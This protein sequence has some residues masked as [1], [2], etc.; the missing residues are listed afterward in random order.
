[1]QPRLALTFTFTNSG[2]QPVEFDLVEVNSLLGNFAPRP[3]KLSLAPGAEG[4]M[5]P[6][7]SNLPPGLEGLEVTLT[8][9]HGNRSETQVL[10]LH[11]MSKPAG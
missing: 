9:K 11:P 3:E 7:L 6:M 4:A 2:P 8:L 10:K 5:E 1:M